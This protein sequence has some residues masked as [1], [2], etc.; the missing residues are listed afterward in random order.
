MIRKI[1]ACA[2]IH[3]RNIQRLGETK[4][5][6]SKFAS[7]CREECAGFAKDEVR[8]VVCG[9]LFTQK[10]EISNES[11]LLAAS[12]IDDLNQIAPT[13]VV[14]GNHDM[15]MNNKDRVD[16]ITPLFIM[17]KFPDAVYLDMNLGYKSGCEEDD[18]IVWCLYSSCDD[19]ALTPSDIAEA[20]TKYGNDKTYVGL[21]HGSV[22]GAKNA[23]GFK[24]DA[25]LSYDSFDGC[26]FVICGHIHK[27][28]DIGKAVRPIVYCGSLIQQNNGESLHDHGYIVWDVQS[29]TYN[30]K[31]LENN[32]YGF[33]Q[34]SINSIEDLKNNQEKILNL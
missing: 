9:D 21:F 33:Y 25:G 27:C 20:K 11:N 24:M 1:I 22:V 32:D 6:L 31:E 8:I 4:E 18:N 30:F 3:I 12:F 13:I 16:S 14:V 26:D 15:L 34:F 7:K 10:I 2:D 5:L 28:Q 17:S 19:F 23:A 29:K